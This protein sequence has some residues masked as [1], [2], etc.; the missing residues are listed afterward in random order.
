MIASEWTV[1]DEE[2]D[3]VAVEGEFEEAFFGLRFI[4]VKGLRIKGRTKRGDPLGWPAE[5][6]PVLV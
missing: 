5:S 4:E 6:G 2:A 3:P 1:V